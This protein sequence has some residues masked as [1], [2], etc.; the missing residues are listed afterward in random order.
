MDKRGQ[1]GIPV[2]QAY[3]VVK[4]IIAVVVVLIIIGIVA[5]ACNFIQTFGLDSGT[6]KT[7]DS[8]VSNINRISKEDYKGASKVEIP[9][10]FV[11]A[12]LAIVGFDIG[13]NS[14][15][16]PGIFGD[17]TVN[18]P[19]ECGEASNFSCLVICGFGDEVNEFSC[20]GDKLI[21]GKVAVF[22][23]VMLKS[24]SNPDKVGFVLIRGEDNSG[25]NRGI[26]HLTIE[27]ADN[28]L[29]ID[30]SEA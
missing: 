1:E 24:K 16:D 3:S 13:Q 10:G 22:K 8:L 17:D 21:G 11:G 25:K 30:V 2:L 26:Q 9:G 18:R 7:F 4:M 29:Y 6:E 14:I 12:D 27:K 23:N 28:I 5:T 15:G 20:S 19:F